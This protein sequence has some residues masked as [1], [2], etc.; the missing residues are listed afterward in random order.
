[1]YTHLD[2]VYSAMRGTAPSLATC[3]AS[4]MLA[5][6]LVCAWLALAPALQVL[7]GLSR[8]EFQIHANNKKNQVDPPAVTGMKLGGVPRS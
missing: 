1:M 5:W 6:G 3:F 2:S 8:D 4:W 7:A